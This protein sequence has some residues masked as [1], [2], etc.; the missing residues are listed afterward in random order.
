LIIYTVPGVDDAF[1]IAAILDTPFD[2]HGIDD[3]SAILV[4]YS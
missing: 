3:Q 1:A 4:R 2:L